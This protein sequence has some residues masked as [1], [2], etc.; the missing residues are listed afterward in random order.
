MNF[1]LTEEQA[2]LVTAVQSV[3]RLH[4]EPPQHERLSSSYFADGLQAKLK[5]DGYLDAIPNGLTPLD[6]A[7][8]LLATSAVPGVTEVGASA[9]VAPL[10]SPDQGIEG[11][12]ALIAADLTAPCRLLPVARS[13]IAIDGDEAV[14]IAAVDSAEVE[15][16]S[17]ILAYPYGRFRT[18]PDLSAG[19]RLG[20]GSAARMRQWHR[21][22]IALEIAAAAESAV[23]F[24]VDYVK[25]RHVFGRPIG[26]FQAVQHRLAQ[27]YQI[28]RAMR[29]LALRAAWSEDPVHASMAAAYAQ[30]HVHKLTFD[31]HQFNGGMG[32]TNEHKLHFWTYRL[33]ALQSEAG[34]ARAAALAIADSRWPTGARAA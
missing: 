4:L 9:L 31:L 33:R 3:C 12:I 26:S 18:Q 22:V 17:T 19:R 30:A 6:A 21:V 29:F 20:P 13:A 16:I 5:A 32:V 28:S 25:Q 14:V 8:I 34:G 24:T 15:P 10:L 1:E 23:A 27:C 11:P 2:V 7:L